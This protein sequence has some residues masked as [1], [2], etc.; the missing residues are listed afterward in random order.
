MEN[1]S[2]AGLV[3]ETDRSVIEAEL[4]R[5]LKERKFSGAPQMSSFLRYIV[6]QTLDGNGDRIKAYTVGVDAL[7]KPYTFD[8]QSD[9]SVRVLALRLRKTLAAIYEANE[10][11]HARIVLRVGTYVPEFLKAKAAD[12]SQATEPSASLSDIAER[13]QVAGHREAAVVGVRSDTKKSD[14]V[15]T[16]D[17]VAAYARSRQ[18]GVSRSTVERATAFMNLDISR[19][20]L[21][22]S[23]L[24]MFV[25]FWLL[26][27][28]HITPYT[29]KL[30]AG[31][32]LSGGVFVDS[33]E[34]SDSD[35]NDLPQV[36]TLYLVDDKTQSQ[37][38]R[39]VSMLMGSSV[40]QTGSLNV[41]RV[42][43][44]R[45]PA[46]PSPGTYH[47]DL[48]ELI[49]DGEVRIDVQLVQIETGAI[50]TTSTLVFDNSTT[51]FSGNEV[52]QVEGFAQQI[53]MLSGLLF[54]DFCN[55]IQDYRRP[56]SCR[57]SPL[58]IPGSRAAGSDSA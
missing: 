44:A 8:A 19:K 31:I 52:D 56:T 55:V 16:V 15:K 36:P 40:V 17:D 42:S 20:Q 10:Y 41:V 57:A 29:K 5:L 50:I 34:T 53:S 3:I 37:R 39:Q 14:S 18:D 7:G 4:A 45:V 28:A 35:A 32:P 13:A 25:A 54:D 23:L 51:G 38:L 22:L 27:G 2:S 58:A 21:L 9:P 11:C 30:S 6:Q 24:V 12:S 26:S 1:S 43:R 49:V 48:N 47:I 46:A 33:P